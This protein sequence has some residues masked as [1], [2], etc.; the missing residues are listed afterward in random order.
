MKKIHEENLQSS[1]RKMEEAS[2]VTRQELKKCFLRMMSVIK[3][4]LDKVELIK[5]TELVLL[6]FSNF[7]LAISNILHIVCR[8]RT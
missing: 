6:N 7:N 4:E 3:V 8:T 5:S 2:E 1:V